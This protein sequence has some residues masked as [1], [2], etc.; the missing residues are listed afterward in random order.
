MPSPFASRVAEAV[1]SRLEPQ[2]AE[3]ADYVD[4]GSGRVSITDVQV[5][6]HRN[7]VTPASSSAPNSG[8]V[9]SGI[10]YVSQSAVA[11]PVIHGRFT[12]KLTGSNIEVWQIVSTPKL[13]N[14][15]FHCVVKRELAGKHGVKGDVNV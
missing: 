6:L 15:R 12:V 11:K 8:E 1:V 10:L 3:L 2:L 4:S 9:H 14:G 13:Q 7:D 5:I